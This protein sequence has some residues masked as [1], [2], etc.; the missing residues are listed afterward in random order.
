M[1]N[2]KHM[3]QLDGLRA[4][5]VALVM[6]GH[7][8]FFVPQLHKLDHYL[9]DVGV[10]SF[11]VLSGFL[12]TSILLTN[13]ST[14]PGARLYTLKQFYIRRFLRIFP[15]YYFVIAAGLLAGIP[16]ARQHLVPLLT[17]TANWVKNTNTNNLGFY[18]HLWSLSV[19][20]QF[21][22]F[23]PALLLL[24]GRR[25]GV[26]FFF[27]LIIIAIAFRLIL[28]IWGLRSGATDMSNWGVYS[29]TPSC[30]DSF[31]I[32]ALLAYVKLYHTEAVKAFLQKKNL[33]LICVTL[34]VVAGFL[35]MEYANPFI[36]PF[37]VSLCRTL[38]SLGS[39][40]VIGNACYSGFKGVAGG[41]LQNRI[42]VYLGKI[43]YGLYIYHYILI[44][45]FSRFRLFRSPFLNYTSTRILLV[46]TTVAVASISW[47]VLEKPIN[48]MKKY[49]AYTRQSKKY[50]SDNNTGDPVLQGVS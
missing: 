13:I 26:T 38:I 21:Y 24:I 2:A 6:F 37:N 12:I 18:L 8:T 33:P 31:G 27:S 23:F 40:W 25:R 48:E 41:F 3:I 19:E 11:F 7:Y 49:F 36:N 30:L 10:T 43:S 17:Y 32:G 47:Y 39:V 4:I 45:P 50:V 28:Y 1:D 14:A 34:F 42:V 22:I 46:L 29:F 44:Y 9:A 16:T 20:E 5:A 15:L 35:D